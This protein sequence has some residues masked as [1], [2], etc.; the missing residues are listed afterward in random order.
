MMSRRPPYAAAGHA[1]ADDLAETDE[2]RG[3][4]VAGVRAAEGDAKAR[5]D[6]VEDQQR[7]VLAAQRA[8]PLEVAR[9]RRDAAHVAGDRL[10][11]DRRDLAGVVGQDTGRTRRRR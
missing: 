10:D 3:D 2:V 5:H 7:A 1:A 6:L 4:A 9:S 11:D 8:Q